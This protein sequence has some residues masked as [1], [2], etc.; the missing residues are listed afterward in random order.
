MRPLND[1]IKEDKNKADKMF[2]KLGYEKDEDIYIITYVNYYDND[3]AFLIRFD[4]KLKVLVFNHA[5][6]M[7]ELQSI[8]EKC[9]ELGWL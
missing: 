1:C 3:N 6:N 4:K 9:K 5:I 8:N 7:E 2:E